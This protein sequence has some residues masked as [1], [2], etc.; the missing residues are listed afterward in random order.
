MSMLRFEL[1]SIMT[2]L[3]TI[4]FFFLNLDGGIKRPQK[5]TSQA[6]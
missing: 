2:E 1:G 5:V 4:D 6:Q 3:S